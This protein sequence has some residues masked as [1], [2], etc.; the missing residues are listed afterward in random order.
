MY[1]HRYLCLFMCIYLFFKFRTDEKTVKNDRT[2]HPSWMVNIGKYRINGKGN[3][4]CEIGKNRGMRLDR[5]KMTQK[6][7]F[8]LFAFVNKRKKNCYRNVTIPIRVMLVLFFLKYSAQDLIFNI[9]IQ[10]CLIE[11]APQVN[12]YYSGP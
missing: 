4:L 9:H 5:K 10:L 12:E 2:C 7:G 8:K 6:E 1:V 11:T 3:P